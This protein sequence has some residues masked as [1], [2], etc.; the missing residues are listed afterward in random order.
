MCMYVWGEFIRAC[1]STYMYVFACICLY[2]RQCLCRNPLQTEICWNAY[3]H[4]F[5]CICMYH[6]YKHVYACISMYLYVYV[7]M[8]IYVNLCC[9]YTTDMLISACKCQA[10][11]AHWHIQAHMTVQTG[12]RTPTTTKTFCFRTD[13][14]L[15][16]KFI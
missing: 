3:K 14:L 9:L 13:F 16:G 7:C 11:V 15:L 12:V 1:I 8:C 5:V 10:A 4:V 2:L 6:M